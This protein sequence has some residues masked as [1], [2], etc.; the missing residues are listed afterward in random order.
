MNQYKEKA[1]RLAGIF[2]VAA[3]ITLASGYTTLAQAAEDPAVEK[4]RAGVIKLISD[5]EPDSIEPSP[6]EGIYEV[7]IGPQ[8]FYVSKDGDYLMTGKMYDI[9]SREDL[10]TSKVS[11][12]K[13]KAVEDIGEEN[14]VIFAPEKYKHTIS[15]FTD[16]D[17]GYCRKLHNEI[18]QYNDLGIRVRYLMFPRAGVGSPSYDKA[19]SVWCADDRKEAMTLSKAGKTIEQ[20]TCENPVKAHMDVGKL[21]GVQGTPA[22]V[23]PSGEMMPGYLPAARMSAMLEGK[24]AQ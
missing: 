9:A 4:V 7:M 1:L 8:L 18:Q 2:T 14:M 17:C 13:A 20:K 21:V 16:I 22:I 23:L 6:I 11:K 15:V 19:V 24:K 10:T 5:G 3:S 12:A